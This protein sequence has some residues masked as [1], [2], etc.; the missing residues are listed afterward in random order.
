MDKKNKDDSR[1]RKHVI[2]F[3]LNDWEY[4]I[5][6]EKVMEAGLTRQLFLLKTVLDCRVG[7][8][9]E[10]ELLRR[11]LEAL[12][13]IDR[14]VKGQGVNLNQMARVANITGTSPVSEKI[15]RDITMNTEIRKGVEKVWQLLRQEAADRP[16][17]H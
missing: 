13:D 9:E 5:L 1:K 10:T 14:Q 4:K 16:M 7:S 12:N 15:E 8:A 11:I 17:H 3:R 2:V 6:M